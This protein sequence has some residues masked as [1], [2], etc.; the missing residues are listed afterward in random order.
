MK[1]APSGAMQLSGR[2]C[3]Y[4][5]GRIAWLFSNAHCL[6]TI[7]ALDFAINI[8]DLL[9]H[10]EYVCAGLCPNSGTPCIYIYIYIYIFLYLCHKKLNEAI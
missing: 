8:F 5:D 10:E 3:E 6:K 2:L 9:F 7:D 1:F 4:F